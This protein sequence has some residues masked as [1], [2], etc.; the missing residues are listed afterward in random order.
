MRALFRLFLLWTTSARKEFGRMCSFHLW[1]STLPESCWNFRPALQCMH[2]TH[3]F[4]LAI[5]ILMDKLGASISYEGNVSVV[6]IS[7]IRN[8]PWNRKGM[9]L[10]SSFFTPLPG[11]LAICPLISDLSRALNI[12]ATS[13]KE[14]IPA[15][16]VLCL[17]KCHRFH[18][19]IQLDNSA[20]PYRS[21]LLPWA[22]TR[23]W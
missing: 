13:F 8:C 23:S 9:S 1:N 16:F 14:R 10:R 2:L 4:S 3:F 21:A 11:S 20:C 6:W 19:H 22:C 18:S 7:L 15:E 12:D 17:V 5:S